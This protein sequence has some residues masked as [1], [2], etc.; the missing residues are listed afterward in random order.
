[1]IRQVARD[2]ISKGSINQVKEFSS[3]A[4]GMKSI[5]TKIAIEG[6]EDLRK[7]TGGVGYLLSS[8]IGELMSDYLW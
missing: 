3:L 6:I 2:T 5:T 8:G 4:A 7:S 1:M